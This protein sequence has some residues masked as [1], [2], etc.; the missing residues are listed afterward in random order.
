MGVVVADPLFIPNGTALC[1]L[2]WSNGESNEDR[3]LS[4]ETLNPSNVKTRKQN[5]H[6]HSDTLQYLV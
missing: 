5:F 6:F 3:D 4:V 1:A 2:G